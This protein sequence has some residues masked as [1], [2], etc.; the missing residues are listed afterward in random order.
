VHSLH[1]A[2]S[3]N[4]PAGRQSGRGGTAAVRHKIDIDPQLALKRKENSRSLSAR[5]P[6]ATNNVRQQQINK[7]G[8]GRSLNPEVRK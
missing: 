8:S 5:Q 2:E 1:R 6:N 7:P 3:K 4:R